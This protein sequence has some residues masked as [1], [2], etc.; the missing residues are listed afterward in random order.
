MPSIFKRLSTGEMITLFLIVAFPIHA[1]SIFMVLQDFQWVMER[2]VSVWDGIGYASYS[3]MFALFESAVIFIVVWLLS[4]L[5]PSRWKSNKIIAGIGTIF[6]SVS[7]W[8]ILNQLYFFYN[9]TSI[10][11]ALPRLFVD[12]AHP[13]RMYYLSVGFV[14]LLI[15]AT[16]VV[17][18][19]FIDRS[20]KY[21]NST[22]A[23][24]DRLIILSGLYIFVDV[25]GIVIVIIRNV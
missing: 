4:L 21:V 3:L 13:V 19:F 9:G 23:V 2:T 14:F 25:I 24:F 8:A 6:I 12:L 16:I 22:M 7:I 17:P 15:L 5:L 1:W 18:L 20:K 11:Q 10:V